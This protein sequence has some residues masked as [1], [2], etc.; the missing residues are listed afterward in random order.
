MFS[1]FI[2]ALEFLACLGF[3]AYALHFLCLTKQLNPLERITWSFA[4]GFGLLGW[5]LFFVGVLWLIT[6]FVLLVT[7]ILGASGTIILLPAKL[8]FQL[9]L[10]N[11]FSFNFLNAIIVLLLAA[12]LTA[13]IITN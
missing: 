2:L 13:D 1:Y 10:K 4:L 11:R 8:E 9:H 3:G 12:V 7:L 5:I 6:D